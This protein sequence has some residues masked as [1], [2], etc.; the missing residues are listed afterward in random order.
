MFFLVTGNNLQTSDQSNSESKENKRNENAVN[1]ESNISPS[2]LSEITLITEQDEESSFLNRSS[3]SES[4]SAAIARLNVTGETDTNQM[5]YI[6]NNSPTQ[7][8][9]DNK[10]S[11]AVVA[12]NPSNYSEPLCNGH[13]SD[14]S[15][16]SSS[17]ETEYSKKTVEDEVMELHNSKNCV[18]DIHCSVASV[19]DGAGEC[20]IDEDELCVT[21]GP[22]L[23]NSVSVES[24]DGEIEDMQTEASPDDGNYV[25]LFL[26]NC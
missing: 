17:M 24:C 15:R 19:V 6:N 2:N 3:G 14:F 26:K 21:D 13:S 9:T 1:M 23:V 25:S 11:N 12:P 7:N 18:S 4:Q 16:D 8:N 20:L 22:K 5:A 10:T